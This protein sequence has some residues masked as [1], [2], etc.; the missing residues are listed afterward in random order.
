[1][2]RPYFLDLRERVVTLVARGETCR[3]IAA[4]FDVSVASVVKTM[5]GKQPY[6]HAARRSSPRRRRVIEKR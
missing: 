3:P 5:G 6:L 4:V 2:A 1:M